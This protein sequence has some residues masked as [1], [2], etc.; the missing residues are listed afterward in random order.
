MRNPFLLLK[1]LWDQTVKNPDKDFGK[2][3]DGP[4]AYDGPNHWTIVIKDEPTDSDYVARG[5]GRRED[6]ERLPT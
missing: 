4:F 3:L 2:V 6:A 5:F 1:I